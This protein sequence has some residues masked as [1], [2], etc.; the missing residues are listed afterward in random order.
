MDFDHIYRSKGFKFKY[1]Y[2]LGHLHKPQSIEVI[3]SFYKE[4][5]TEQEV[6]DEKKHLMKHTKL[7]IIKI[8]IEHL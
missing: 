6:E 8:D 7:P 4:L 1:V 3:N 2:T 5:L